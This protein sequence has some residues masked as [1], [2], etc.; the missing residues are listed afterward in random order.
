MRSVLHACR[1]LVIS[2][3]NLSLIGSRYSY[4]DYEKFYE[5]TFQPLQISDEELLKIPETIEQQ[6]PDGEADD[7]DQER[8]PVNQ[9][10]TDDFEEDL[11]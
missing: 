7:E 4:K 3:H 9:Q 2:E 11:W 10:Q 1:R 8:K 5:Q 6:E